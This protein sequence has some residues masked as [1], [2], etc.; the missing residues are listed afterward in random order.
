MG[1]RMRRRHTERAQFGGGWNVL[2][3]DD[4]GAGTRV[5]ATRV[6][7]CGVADGMVSERKLPRA[8]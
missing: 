6:G 3:G 8:R 4:M 5:V 7:R 2:V 1:E